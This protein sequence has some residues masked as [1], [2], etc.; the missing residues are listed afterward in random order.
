MRYWDGVGWTGYT[1]PPS[2]LHLRL[3]KY[4][5]I[6][7][8]AAFGLFTLIALSYAE[9][10]TGTTANDLEVVDAVLTALMFAILGSGLVAL[11]EVIVGSTKRKL[12]RTNGTPPGWYRDMTDPL[13]ARYWD[14]SR[15]TE[16][17]DRPREEVDHAE[18]QSGL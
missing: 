7:A 15:W 17:V 16:Y 4:F 1:T 12:L 13:Q 10:P 6:A 9:P 5:G 3:A 14:G 8:A 18:H 11:I 2:N